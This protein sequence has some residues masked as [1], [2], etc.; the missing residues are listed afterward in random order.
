MSSSLPKSIQKLID[1]FARLPGIGPKSAER[2][3]IHLLHSPDSRVRDFGN[4]VISMKNGVEFCGVCWHLTDRNPCSICDDSSRDHGVICAVEQ[5]LDVVAI[6]RSGA[7]KGLY[8]VLHGV[9]S[10]IHGV[11]PEQL[12]IAEL[13]SRVRAGCEGNRRVAG[14]DNDIGKISEVIFAMN[15][16]LEGET[17]ALYLTKILKKY[18]VRLTRIA[19]GLPIGG[20]LGYADQGTLSKAMEGRREFSD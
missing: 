12:K 19:R 17:T 2:L 11:G 10:P 4:A 20:E 1:E 8:H 13:E 9:L 15:P 14:G 6:E 5:V 16:S 3:A 18:P 7:Y